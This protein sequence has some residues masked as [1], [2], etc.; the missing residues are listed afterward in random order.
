MK[1][2]KI[3]LP[4]LC[5][6][7]S[8]PVMAKTEDLTKDV[9]ISANSWDG[10]L[11]NNQLNYYG[12]VIVT[13]GTIKITAE[14]LSAF[15]D[16]ASGNK[17]FNATGSPATF[18]QILDTGEPGKA[19]AKQ[20]RYDKKSGTLVLKGNAE[21]D[22]G[23]NKMKAE[24]IRYNIENQH[25]SADSSGNGTDRVKTII[26]ADTYQDKL[27]KDKSEKPNSDMK[28]KADKSKS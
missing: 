7:L 13:Q 2:N 19:S 23:G 8:A 28:S 11:K 3:F 16:K 4:L 6:L 26:P 25:V 22:V 24:T 12:D 17:I 9:D 20:I 1:L 21:L 27:K 10:S 15:S 18:F 5:C 14:R